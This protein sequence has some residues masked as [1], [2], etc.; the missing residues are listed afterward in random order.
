MTLP[1][2]NITIDDLVAC[3]PQQWDVPFF[4]GDCWEYRRHGITAQDILNCF[5]DYSFI[6]TSRSLLLNEWNDITI[7]DWTVSPLAELNGTIITIGTWTYDLNS[8]LQ[9]SFYISDGAN[10]YQIKRDG[11]MWVYWE[12]WLTMKVVWDTIEFGLPTPEA[13]Y[14]I[15]WRPQPAVEPTEEWT[16]YPYNKWL[17]LTWDD[18]AKV[19]KWI[20]PQCCLQT[21]SLE[22]TALS[23]EPNDPIY[24]NSINT[25]NQKLSIDDNLLSLTRRHWGLL[26]QQIADPDSEIDLTNVAEEMLVIEWWLLSIKKIVNNIQSC[27]S[28]LSTTVDLSVIDYDCN[29]VA[30][31]VGNT[32][33]YRPDYWVPLHI[34]NVNIDIARYNFF[35]YE[36]T[37]NNVISFVNNMWT[38]INN[39][40]IIISETIKRQKYWAK[41]SIESGNRRM[42]SKQSWPDYSSDD[43]ARWFIPQFDKWEWR[44]SSVTKTI[45]PALE[46][47]PDANRLVI[48]GVLN[49]TLGTGYDQ[50]KS[51]NNINSSQENSHFAEGWCKTIQIPKTWWYQLNLQWV[52]EVDHNVN[53]FR[54]SCLRFNSITNKVDLLLDSKFGGWS[55]VGSWS[56]NNELVPCTNQYLWG[57]SKLVL[58]NA[59]DI[60]FPAVKIDPRVIRPKNTNYTATKDVLHELDL[61]IS[62]AYGT[63][64]HTPWSASG[65]DVSRTAWYASIVYNYTANI[66]WPVVGMNTLPRPAANLPNVSPHYFTPHGGLDGAAA[67]GWNLTY[68]GGN[69]DNAFWE[70]RRDDGCV[71]LYKPSTFFNSDWEWVMEGSSEWASLSVHW[72]NAVQ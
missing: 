36:Q 5:N 17:V 46:I 19:A 16:Y 58:L 11:V 1:T 29:D 20:P 50:T 12:D 53:A 9:T 55:S 57:G 3:K 48:I 40:L 67:Y 54:Y 7:Q 24:L 33:I 34:N 56:V 2:L 61:D 4:N 26:G 22:W 31:C 68:P 66:W 59:W 69:G 30:N 10:N 70:Y 27:N 71:T 62:P 51:A 72:V 32:P 47:V 37:I 65:P 21:L 52:L 23:I 13:S 39:T 38:E 41:I 6:I 63:F 14:F 49:T 18:C 45:D 28:C 64:S 15:P 42:W 35:Q 43:N 44:E 25:D 60:L 8:F